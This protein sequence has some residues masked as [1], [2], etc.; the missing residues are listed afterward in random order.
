V[1]KG[2]QFRGFLLSRVRGILG[3]ISSIPLVLVIL[4]DQI[5]AIDAHEV[6][7]LF[8]KCCAF[9][10]SESEDRELDLGELT[11]GLLFNPRTQA[12]PV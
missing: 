8:P 12:S 2:A 9:L 3:G 7:L 6:F 1:S 11:C 4:V 5:L 10:W